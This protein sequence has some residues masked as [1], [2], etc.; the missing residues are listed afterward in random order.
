MKACT[1]YTECDSPSRASSK[2]CAG[3]QCEVKMV[4]VWPRVWRPT[5]ASM[6]RRSAPPMPRSGWKK[7]IFFFLVFAIV[8]DSF[9]GGG[10]GRA[11]LC[12]GA[13]FSRAPSWRVRG[14][15]TELCPWRITNKTWGQIQHDPKF[16]V[17]SRMHFLRVGYLSSSKDLYD[18]NIR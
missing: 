1:S 9:I 4:T 8:V 17:S 12:M 15:S 16:T 11:S 2:Q 13:T 6:T 14:S 10:C 18:F 3:S 7:T 5:A